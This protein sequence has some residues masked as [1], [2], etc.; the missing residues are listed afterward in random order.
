MGF[1]DR[2]RRKTPVVSP[3]EEPTKPTTVYVGAKN[4]DPERKDYQSYNNQNITFSGELSGYDYDSILRNKQNNIVSLYQLSDY[5]CDADPLVH[6]IIKH[7]YVPYSMSSPWFLTGATKK[8]RD[9]YEEFYKQI[10]LREKLASIFLE[11]WE[12]A[13]RITPKVSRK[14]YRK[15]STKANS[16]LS[17]IQSI[18]KSFNRIRKR[19]NV[20]PFLS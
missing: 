10:R 14:K 20:M 12:Y 8:T 18:V 6:G 15:L 7:V 17:L 4:E 3:P 13:I 11:Y 19:G 16:M 1:F 5:Y 9:I 2:F